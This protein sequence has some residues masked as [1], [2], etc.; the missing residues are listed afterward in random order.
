MTI[1]DSIVFCLT[2]F[3]II[4][5]ASRGFMKSLLGPISIIVATALSIL[6]YNVTKNMM[7]SLLI[8]VFGP[9]LL[10]FIL[11]FLLQSW[12]VFTNTQIKP[13]FLSR[14]SGSIITLAWGW[15][16]II[17]TL[18]LLSLLPIWNKSLKAL[19]K[20]VLGS[21]SYSFAKPLGDIF[22][23]PPKQSTE[24]TPTVATN[25]DVK[26]LADD[27]RFQ[28]ILQ[29]P[30]IQAEINAH[31]FVKLMSNPKMMELTREI[32]NDPVTMKKV[33]SIYSSQKQPPVNTP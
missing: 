14:L 3:F 12:A 11:Q 10:S 32:M 9:F 27:P 21:A 19:H 17:F 25:T 2:I 33:L 31:D 8:G 23:I 7:I 29:D 6:Y 5:G 18:I 1:T 26:S 30:D 15:V 16:F 28:K 24:A 22:F 13:N 20:D 4:R